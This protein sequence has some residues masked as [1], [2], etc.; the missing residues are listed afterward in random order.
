V[1]FDGTPGELAALGDDR[2]GA[3]DGLEPARAIERGLRAL[4]TR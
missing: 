4:G 1:C 2:P 3:A